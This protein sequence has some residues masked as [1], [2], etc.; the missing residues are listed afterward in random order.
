MGSPLDAWDNFYVIVG[1]SAGAL[2]GLQFVVMALIADSQATASKTTISAF[3][4]PT[5]AH[6][7]AVL[8]LAAV[9]S[10]PWPSLTWPAILLVLLGIVGIA[11]TTIVFLRTRR[12]TDYKPVAEDWVFH[13]ILPFVAYTLLLIG[14]FGLTSIT[15]AALFMIGTMGV[16][17]LF[18]GIHNAWDTVTF[19]VTEKMGPRSE[20]S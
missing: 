9:V 12:V 11:Y 2:T 8:G 13:V 20:S 15:E 3:G 1:S 6:F 19:I 5:I 7:C 16:I 18:V 4:T 14:A 17:L 10:A